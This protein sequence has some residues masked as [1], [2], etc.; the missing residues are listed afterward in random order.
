MVSL[1]FRE[2]PAR[3]RYRWMVAS[4]VPRPIAFV[5]SISPNGITNLAPF[6]YF[7]GVSSDPPVITISVTWRRGPTKDTAVNI[8]AT[9]EFVVNIVTRT[10]L[11]PMNLC[12]G[13]YPYETSEF[14]ISGLTA[15]ASSIVKPP[16]VAES[17]ISMECRLLQ[18]VKV[19]DPATSIILGEVVM[20]HA[21][22][23]ILTEGL[24]DPRKLDPVARLGGTLYSTVGEIIDLPR[25][26]VK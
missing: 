15:V 16:R 18:I 22:E 14:D 5:S 6:S 25:P 10:I 9:G 19:G 17:P 2:L 11:E 7:N 8:E 12:S 3:E 26:V 1:D 21:D 4:I 13:D 23:Q 24:P 20:L